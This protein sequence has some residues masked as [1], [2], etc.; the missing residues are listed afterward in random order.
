M[1]GLRVLIVDDSEDDALLIARRL[2]KEGH[3]AEVVRVETREGM[4]AVIGRPWDVIISDVNMPRFS[5]EGALA[6]RQ[7]MAA[8]VPFI[9]VSGAVGEEAAVSF[10]KRGASDFVLKG[11]LAL[12]VPA[13]ERAMRDAEAARARRRAEE[14]LRAAKADLERALAAKTRFLAAASHDLRQPVQA[15]YCFHEVLKIQLDGHPAQRVAADFGASLDGLRSLLDSLLDVS[16]I[17]SGLVKPD[18]RPVRL[19]PV[20]ARV[21][22]QL[23]IVACQKGLCL[24]CVPTRAVVMTDEL[25]LERIL[26]N[27]V[28][29]A[30]KY[31]E[32]GKIVVGCRRDGTAV[33]L[34]VFDTGIGIPG[35]LRAQIFEEFFQ[36]AN[37]ERDR[38]K[39]IGLGLSIVQRLCEML[40]HP[41]AVRSVLGKGSA[42]AVSL[43]LVGWAAA[44][45]D[46]AGVSSCV[47]QRDARGTRAAEA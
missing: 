16:R 22:S 33:R 10:L 29:N 44:N 14:D 43:P 24:R 3:P 1:S 23:A 42:F 31:S 40:G 9:V 17:D 45:E 8:Q 19:H 21:C 15:L 27:L 34:T 46:T 18:V 5:V 39:G 38:R 2:R 28:E 20:L 37:S 25:L 13:I 11:K 36:V 47:R 32:R 4:E 35:E 26:R 7:R 12:L 41:I 30:V 6:V